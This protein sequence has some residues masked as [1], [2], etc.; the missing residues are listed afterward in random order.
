MFLAG[1]QNL[2][3]DPRL[4]HS[5]VT[6]FGANFYEEIQ[7]NREPTYPAIGLYQTFDTTTAP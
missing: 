5:G 7:T 3:L 4:E 2:G 1:I 6:P